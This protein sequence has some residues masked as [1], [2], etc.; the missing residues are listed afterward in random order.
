M[1]HSKTYI[2]LQGILLIQCILFISGCTILD[3]GKKNFKQAERYERDIVQKVAP[4]VKSTIV[5]QQLSTI[6]TFD[7]LFLTDK[8]RM[9]YVD[10]YTKRHLVSSE[11]ES[12]MRQRLLN[13]NKYYI[14]FYVVGAQ[15]ENLYVSSHALFTGEYHKQA[16]LLGEKDAEW[17][18]YMKVDGKEYAPDSIRVVEL[19]IEYQHFLASRYS[20]F[21]SVYLVKFDSVDQYDQEILSEG[22]HDVSLT[23]VSP[24][25][26]AQLEWNNVEYFLDK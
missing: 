4:Y 20:Q 13:E 6:A 2:L 9:M 7:A 8:M 10:Y 12:I 21:K 26:K 3:W 11:K 25:Y 17:Q 23:L 1:K 5:Y 22:M 18:L 19:P 15:T 24:R 14:S 16:S